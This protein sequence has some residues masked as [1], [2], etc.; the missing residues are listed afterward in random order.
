MTSE[1]PPSSVETYD[2]DGMYPPG[3][4]VTAKTKLSTFFVAQ[5]EVYQVGG[6]IRLSNVNQTGNGRQ[7]LFFVRIFLSSSRISYHTRIYYEI[8]Y[9]TWRPSTHRTNID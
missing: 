1:S 6:F 8:W 4:F 9:N 5:L 3:T 7:L 2:K